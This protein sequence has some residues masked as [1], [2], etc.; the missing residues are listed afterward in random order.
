M[1][2]KMIGGWLRQRRVVFL[3]SSVNEVLR[4]FYAIKSTRPLVVFDGMSNRQYILFCNTKV[5]SGDM[6]SP[7]QMVPSHR[8]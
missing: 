1:R 7:S 6:C 4:L 3:Q 8:V 2:A 5:E